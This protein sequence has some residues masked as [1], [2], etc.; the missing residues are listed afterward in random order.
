MGVHTSG[1]Y[2][3]ESKNYRGVIVG[4]DDSSVLR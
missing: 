3:V 2:V 4:N 1:I